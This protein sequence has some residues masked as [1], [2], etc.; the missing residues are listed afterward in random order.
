MKNELLKIEL[1]GKT[2]TLNLGAATWKKY[3]KEANVPWS[4]VP[5]TFSGKAALKSFRDLLFCGIT[6]NDKR[7]HLPP[8]ITKVQLTESLISDIENFIQ[9]GR[10]L[11]AK[12]VEMAKNFS[13]FN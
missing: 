8:S 6:E 11:C 12:L 10:V 4:K 9:I 5:D 2:Y 13:F 7:L 3:C 1:S